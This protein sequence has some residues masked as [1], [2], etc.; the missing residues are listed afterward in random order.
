MS[1]LFIFVF[2]SN[3]VI[4]LNKIFDERAP[5]HLSKQEQRKHITFFLPKKINVC[6]LLCQKMNYHSI[7]Q[8]YHVYVY[9]ITN[10]HIQINLHT[11]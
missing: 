2:S 1:F 10:T 5:I 8:F 11:N 7:S 6:K 4:F 3:F 9:K